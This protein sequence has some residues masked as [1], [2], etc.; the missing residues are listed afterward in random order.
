MN[1]INPRKL[2]LSKW[3]AVSPVEKRKH[4][5]VIKLVLDEMTQDVVGC[6]LQAVIDKYEMQMDWRKLKNINTWRQGWK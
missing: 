5:I 6:I 4:F 2:L 1:Q 3:T